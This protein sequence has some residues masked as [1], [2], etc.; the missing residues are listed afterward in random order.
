MIVLTASGQRQQAVE[1]GLVLLRLARQY[2]Q[3]P[4]IISMMVACAVRSLMVPSL[5]DAIATGPLSPEL[6]Q[7]LDRELVAFDNP[8]RMMWAL[9]SERAFAIDAQL[10][11]P[12]NLHLSPAPLWLFHMFAW[13]GQQ[14][15]IGAIDFLADEIQSLSQAHS[16][17]ENRGREWRLVV[18]PSQHGVLADLM[19]PAVQ[20]TYTAGA[21]A[22]ALLRSLLVFNALCAYA[23]KN[24]REAKGLEELGLPR[25]ATIDPFSGEPLKL[26]HTDDGWVVYSVMTNGV[27][28]GGDF[29]DMKDYGV[30]PRKWRQRQ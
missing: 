22:S 4:M 27:D 20:A 25:E 16:E 8:R 28:D 24:G 29:K 15:H 14:Y 11:P 23:E 10:T 7:E 5:Y 6:R 3:E 13:R 30:A 12:T 19:I 2:D 21:R 17:V 9:K 26:Q 1:K 18:K